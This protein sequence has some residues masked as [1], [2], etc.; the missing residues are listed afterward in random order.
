[1]DRQRAHSL[2]RQAGRSATLQPMPI[3]PALKGHTMVG[4]LYQRRHA[5]G[6]RRTLRDY[7]VWMFLVL[8]EPSSIKPPNC[9]SQRDHLM[10]PEM[11]METRLD[12]LNP[13]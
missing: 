6:C 2:F 4:S 12:P 8:P 1:V 7:P 13:F 5:F 11:G 10:D 9:L 3:H